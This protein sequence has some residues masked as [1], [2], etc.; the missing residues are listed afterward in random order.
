MKP[1]D[2]L[3][4][5]NL[6]R[7]ISLLPRDESK[8]VYVFILGED[9]D[10]DSYK[11]GW[12]DE[13]SDKWL[14]N[15]QEEYLHDDLIGLN[16][17]VFMKITERP[18]SALRVAVE[19]LRKA[20]TTAPCHSQGWNEKLQRYEL[21]PTSLEEQSHAQVLHMHKIIVEAL[22]EINRIAEEK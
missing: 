16:D 17:G 15:G 14:L 22:A 5:D 12:F 7:D 11:T 6:W 2:K 18:A 4:A 10:V 20:A 19:A 13:A 8:D 3:I 1:T 9:V 21:V